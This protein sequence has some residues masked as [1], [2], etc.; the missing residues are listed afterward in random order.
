[1][2]S[3]VLFRYVCRGHIRFG[4]LLYEAIQ[5]RFRISGINMG[6]RRR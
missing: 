3:D 2:K 6:T 4:I 5:D 1:M